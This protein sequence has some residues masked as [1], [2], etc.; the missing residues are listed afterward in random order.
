MYGLAHLFTPY[1]SCGLSPRDSRIAFNSDA[2]LAQPLTENPLSKTPLC[3]RF[4]GKYVIDI[5]TGCHVWTASTSS[6]HKYP[7][8]ASEENGK[9]P[10][11]A[12]RASWESANGP[13]PTTPPPDGSYRWEFHHVCQNKRCV[14][15]AHVRLV[16]QRQHAAI[17][18]DLRR[19]RSQDQRPRRPVAPTTPASPAAVAYAEAA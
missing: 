12:Y 1:T 18:A 17:H 5:Q 14:N 15:A 13:L 16:S 4:V 19:R 6:Q 8:I 9:R 7:T 3:D 2:A 10:V 11:Y